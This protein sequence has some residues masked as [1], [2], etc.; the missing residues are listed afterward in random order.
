MIKPTIGRIVWF[1]RVGSTPG[2]DQPEAATICYVWDDS[3]VNLQVVDNQGYSRSEVGVTLRQ[4]E[5]SRDVP[6]LPYA[7]WMPYQKGQ[8]TRTEELEAALKGK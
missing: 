4:P 2:R 8:A 7:E 6:S 3:K 5:D 1:W